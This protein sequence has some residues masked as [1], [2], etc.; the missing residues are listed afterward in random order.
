MKVQ[1]FMYPA[2]FVLLF[3]MLAYGLFSLYTNSVHVTESEAVAS[4]IEKLATS[5][6]IVKGTVEDDGRGVNLRRDPQNPKE[7]SAEVIPGT[8]YKVNVTQ[9]L[10][11]DVQQGEQIFVSVQGGNYKG[12]S[13]PLKSNVNA[14]DSYV[15]FLFN[16]AQGKPHYYDGIQPNIFEEK[17][18]KMRAVTNVKKYKNIFEDNNLPR[19]EF[20]TKLNQALGE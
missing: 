5:P 2:L 8:E 10:K 20:L 7:E 3:V 13:K 14:E 4:N 15:F 11:G 19:N 16:A 17:E 18:N 1:R 6:V 9:V 12:K